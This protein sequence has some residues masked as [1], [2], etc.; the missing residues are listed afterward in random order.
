L[1]IKKEIIGPK[2]VKN[3]ADE[4]EDEQEEVKM[5]NYWSLENKN[6][7][8]LS[9]LDKQSSKNNLQVPSGFK[10]NPYSVSDVS[11]TPI[12]LHKRGQ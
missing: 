12:P 9:S 6:Y 3:K 5:S 7:I 8:G 1:I 2:T 4:I 11:V 10:S